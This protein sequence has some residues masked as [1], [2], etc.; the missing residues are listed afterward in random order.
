MNHYP[1]KTY[2]VNHFEINDD[3]LEKLKAWREFGNWQQEVRRMVERDERRSRVQIPIHNGG[4]KWSDLLRMF[5]MSFSRKQPRIL[6]E[7]M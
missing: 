1:H 7:N 2:K 5:Q 3:Q 4:K 6:N